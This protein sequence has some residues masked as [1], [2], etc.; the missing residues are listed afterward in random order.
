MVDRRCVFISFRVENE[1][2]QLAVDTAIVIA[3]LIRRI[4]SGNAVDNGMSW[5]SISLVLCTSL[6][7]KNFLASDACDSLIAFYKRSKFVN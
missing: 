2:S 1:R 4:S 7:A 6:P 3:I 5:R